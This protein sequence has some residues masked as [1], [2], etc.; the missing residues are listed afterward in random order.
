[1]GVG[2]TAGPQWC[3]LSLIYSLV[4]RLQSLL[5]AGDTPEMVPGSQ[6]QSTF[7]IG[8][9]DLNGKCAFT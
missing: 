4:T 8:F 6:R 5:P 7:S 3:E 9:T 2:K 1:M